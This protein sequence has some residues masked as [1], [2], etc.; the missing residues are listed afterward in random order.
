MVVGFAHYCVHTVGL[1]LAMLLL[2]TPVAGCLGVIGGADDLGADADGDGVVDADDN[3]PDIANPTQADGD[4]DGIGDACDD[5]GDRDGDGVADADDNCPDV[6]NPSQ[7]DHDGDGTGDACE[8]QTG[9]PDAP[10]IIPVTPLGADYHD[11]RDTS[12]STFDSIDS[13]PPDELDESGPEYYY[14]FTLPAKMR[15]RASLAPEPDGVDIDVQLVD[16]ISPID[17]VDRGDTRLSAVLDPGTYYLLADTYGGDA[18]AGAYQLHVAI[19]PWYP[20]T[21]DDPVRFGVEDVTTPVTLPLVYVD[22]RSTADAASDEIDAYPPNELDE[23]GPEVVYGFTVDQPVYFAVELLLPEPDGADVDVHL[24]S[25]LDPPTLIDRGDYKV[26]AELEPGTYYVV[27]DTY[28][29]DASAGGYTLNLTLRPREL[30]P[31]TLFAPYMVAAT[32]WL[33]QNYGLLGYDIGSVLTHDFPYGDYGVI[34]QSGV[35]G[36][37]MCVAAVM[38]IILTAIQLYVEDTGDTTAWDFLPMDSYRYLG[39]GDIRAHL[40]VNYGDIDSGGSADAL[41]HF[42]MGI[43]VPFERLVPGSV[44]NINRTTGTGHAVVFLAFL[45]LDGN[46]YDVYPDDVEIVGFKYF[47][48]QGSSE[49]GVG[50]M[51]YRWAVFSDYGCPAMPGPRD[52]NVIYSE[53]QH[54]L[55]TGVIY[56]PSQWRTAYYTMLDDLAE[57]WAVAQSRVDPD[58]FDGITTDDPISHR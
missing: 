20:G 36:K 23:S 51:D 18:Q 57:N 11:A 38:E 41:R 9:G 3:C 26:L 29:G 34:P 56:A 55:N 45:D 50:G 28:G 16:E 48:S 17:L 42:G 31:D 5:D 54:Y 15:V 58:Y 39:A 33:Y 40:W 22:Q 43:N 52:C 1:G 30:D 6:A 27:A 7:T 53:S 24:L 25:S 37:T 10:F 4:A 19:E 32:D 8:V 35:E 46:E 47:S 12:E 14:V 2:V 49:V 44:V 21:I 13:Y